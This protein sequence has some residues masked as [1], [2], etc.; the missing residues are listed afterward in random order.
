MEFD[1]PTSDVLAAL[2]ES[3]LLPRLE[4]LT[5]RDLVIPE[6]GGAELLAA[7]APR[8]GHLTLRVTGAVAVEGL[9]EEEVRRVLPALV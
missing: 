9:D 8:F 6:E 4:T 7:L 3:P 5:V 1:A 2:A